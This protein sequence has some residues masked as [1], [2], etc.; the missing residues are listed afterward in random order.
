MEKSPNFLRILALA[1]VVVIV[2]AALYIML[3]SD[4]GTNTPISG[5]DDS[6]QVDGMTYYESPDYLI[7]F[8]YPDTY[9]LTQHGEEFSNS[10]DVNR[11]TIV[12]MNK[13]AASQMPE[14]GEG[15]TV[16]TIDIFQSNVHTQTLEELIRTH[17]ALNF[18]LSLDQRLTATTLAGRPALSY[19]WDGLYRGYSIATGHSIYYYIFSVTTL[20]QSDQIRADF[21]AVLETVRFE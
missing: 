4:R 19:S 15:P 7:S 16:I 11:R 8:S 9:V 3:Q 21:D 2:G 14:N 18:Q 17:P 10:N 1:V 13:I 20:E 6:E 12:L 5:T